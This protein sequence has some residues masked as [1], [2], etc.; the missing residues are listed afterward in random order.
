MWRLSG[1][2]MLTCGELA[3]TRAEPSGGEE[4]SGQW[5][6]EAEHN[7]GGASVLHT[8]L[9]LFGNR[10]LAFRQGEGF[11]CILRG[12]LSPFGP[13][14][15]LVVRRLK[16]RTAHERQM[17][18]RTLVP[19]LSLPVSERCCVWLG[20]FWDLG[21]APQGERSRCGKGMADVLVANVPG[22]VYLGGLTRP[23]TQ[24]LLPAA[25][26]CE[27][28]SVPGLGRLSVTVIT[29]T[30]L[31]AANR[32]RMRN[33]SPSPFALFEALARSFVQALA[34]GEWRQP[35]LQDCLRHPASLSGQCS[36]PDDVIGGSAITEPPQKR[37]RST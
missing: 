36:T 28:L 12:L 9:T 37:L 6:A 16:C 26:D 25:E 11:A 32:A 33:T 31:F 15:A 13:G 20:A 35:H 22:T 7:D 3:F 27:L 17:L 18:V 10:H 21:L 5:W 24:V 8:G 30:A 1:E 34:Q 19:E 4:P 14:H 23:T 29:R 2:W